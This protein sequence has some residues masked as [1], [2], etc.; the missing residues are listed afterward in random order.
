MYKG[1]GASRVAQVQLVITSGVP[2][3]DG[4][5][6][7]HLPSCHCY[8][9]PPRGQT[10][11]MAYGHSRQQTAFWARIPLP[12]TDQ[13]QLHRLAQLGGMHI[14]TG[15]VRPPQTMRPQPHAPTPVVRPHG[16]CSISLT[17]DLDH[18]WAAAAAARTPTA[19]ATRPPGTW[20]CRCGTGRCG[21][22]RPAGPGPLRRGGCC[23]CSLISQSN[24]VSNRCRCA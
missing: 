21:G 16:I 22:S 11:R 12:L 20:R 14:G 24:F 8:L 18:T 15:T 10:L 23:Q 2:C 7:V 3:Q 4:W 1:V 17:R 9:R 5:M 6:A 13:A 19:A